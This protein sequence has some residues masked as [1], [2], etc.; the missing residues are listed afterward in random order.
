MLKPLQSGIVTQARRYRLRAQFHNR[1]T[2]RRRISTTGRSYSWRPLPNRAMPVAATTRPAAEPARESISILPPSIYPSHGRTL[3]A[4]GAQL[5]ENCGAGGSR[6]PI[7]DTDTGEGIR[8]GRPNRYP[9][10]VSRIGAAPRSGCCAADRGHRAQAYGKWR[11]SAANERHATICR[12][13]EYRGKK[14][15]VLTVNDA[16]GI[17]KADK[18]ADY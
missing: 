8:M 18:S 4:R 7:Q 10:S 1:F 2:A 15:L 16:S 3:C 6:V 12:N 11:R 13:T 14:H 9:V 17:C 5:P